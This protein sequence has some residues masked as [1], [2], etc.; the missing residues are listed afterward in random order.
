MFTAP[1]MCDQVDRFRGAASPDEL[2]A[3]RAADEVADGFTGLF[4]R[5]SGPVAERV[6][7]AMHIG[8]ILA[9]VVGDGLAHCLRL[10]RRCRVVQIYQW[11]AV[12]P[13]LQNRK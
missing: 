7:T 4:E 2:L 12:D 9:I 8:V 11:V 6:C 13:L 1:A 5:H 3:R 10:L